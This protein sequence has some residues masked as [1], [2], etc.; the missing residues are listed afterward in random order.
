[1]KFTLTYHPMIFYLI[2]ILFSLACTPFVAYFSNRGQNDKVIL[3]LCLTL[4]LP[5][6]TAIALTYFSGNKEMIQDLW[7]RLILVKIQPIY[8]MII[9]LFMPCLTLLATG[10]SLAFGYSSEQFFLAKSLSV[11][12][13]WSILGIFVPLVL[14][15]L[16]EEF[17]WRGYGVDSLRS[18]FNLFVT[19]VLFGT[20]WALWHL[21]LF[22]VKGCYQNQLFQLGPIY[23]LNFFLSVFV[24][25]FIMN[26]IFY[27]TGRSIPALILFHSMINL[28]AMLFRTE[29]L[30]KC[31]ATVLL[32]LVLAFIVIQNKAI[33][34][35]K[36]FFA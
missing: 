27:Q 21:P 26:W 18:H 19:S 22:F 2:T 4:F 14:A 1:M 30:T 29:P 7:S 9:I 32:C 6:L 17:G 12:K 15:P 5:C 16:I 31:I 33:F 34:F 24:I 20:L 23:V 36:R 28:S 3:L 25:A 11:M 8:L 35:E 10:I 13:G